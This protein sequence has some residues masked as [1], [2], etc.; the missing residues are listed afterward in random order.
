MTVI[1]SI[2]P[3]CAEHEG[4]FTFRGHTHY[5]PLA[6]QVDGDAVQDISWPSLQAPVEANI[7]KAIE[8]G[9]RS[10]PSR[11][12]EAAEVAP[13]L[14]KGFE[15]GAAHVAIHRRRYSVMP[16][17]NTGRVRKLAY[18]SVVVRLHPC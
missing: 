18:G 17:I 5:V 16:R 14:D 8:G 9:R 10:P 6:V 12:H 3:A 4:M 15:D 7:K 2:P 11:G 13:L 1:D